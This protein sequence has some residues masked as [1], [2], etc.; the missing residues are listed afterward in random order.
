MRAAEANVVK[1]P[2]DG[3]HLSIKRKNG[4][5]LNEQGDV[6]PTRPPTAFVDMRNMVL[7]DGF[8]RDQRTE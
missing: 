4:L 7:E 1:D 8:V 2:Q 5:L 3:V 6:I